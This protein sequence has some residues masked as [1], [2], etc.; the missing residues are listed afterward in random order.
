MEIVNYKQKSRLKQYIMYNLVVN[1][2]IIQNY[3]IKFN[4]LIFIHFLV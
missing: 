4:E 3:S 2:N 1:I